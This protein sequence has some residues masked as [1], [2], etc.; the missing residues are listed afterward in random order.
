M[1]SAMRLDGVFKWFSVRLQQLM[2]LFRFP[3]FV[4]CS[5][6]GQLAINFG[7]RQLHDVDPFGFRGG[8]R[9]GWF[10]TMYVADPSQ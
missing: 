5:A 7:C 3:L 9:H 10:R 8:L 6:R 2:V 4:D 1:R